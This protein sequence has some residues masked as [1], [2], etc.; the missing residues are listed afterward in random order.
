M[1]LAVFSMKSFA[2]NRIRIAILCLALVLKKSHY[3]VS[4]LTLTPATTPEEI[5]QSQ[6]SSLQE[7]DMTGVFDFASPANRERVG[8]DVNRF[9]EMV[10]SGPYKYLISHTKADIL[11]YS[12]MGQ[13]KQ[14]LVRVIPSGLSG[15]PSIHEY[16]WSLSRV[17]TGPT[18]GCYMVDA[19]IPNA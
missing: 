2:S 12:Q 16:W 15:R 11:L 8:G 9:G 18:A 19:V 17:R 5:I 7:D 1:I 4:G 10:R 6:L 14:Y 13:S 3:F